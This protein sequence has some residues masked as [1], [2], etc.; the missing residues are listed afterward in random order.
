M[1]KSRKASEST[2]FFRRICSKKNSLVSPPISVAALPVSAVWTR[3]S[4][5][6][7][8]FQSAWAASIM[9]LFPVPPS[10]PR[11]IRS[12]LSRRTEPKSSTG[13]SDSS[14]RFHRDSSA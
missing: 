6:P 1:I 14:A 12:W 13:T 7:Q 5:R 10:P 11:N 4:E 3:Q 2:D 9:R 8:L